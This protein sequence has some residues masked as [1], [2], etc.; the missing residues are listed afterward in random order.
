MSSTCA[1]HFDN[2][3]KG[4]VKVTTSADEI[5]QYADKMIGHSLVTKQT[6]EKGQMT[7]QV[8]VL[9][10]INFKKVSCI[11]AQQYMHAI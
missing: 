8:L 2:G 1:G 4:G 5:Q 9:E 7:R 10:S 6:G 3:F 11:T